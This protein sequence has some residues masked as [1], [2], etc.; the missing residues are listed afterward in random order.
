MNLLDQYIL[1]IFVFCPLIASIFIML[2]PAG[3]LGSKLVASKFFALLGFFAYARLMI[4]FLDQSVPTEVILSLGST[5]FRVNLTLFVSKYNMIMYGVASLVLLYNVFTYDIDNAKT[6]I[7]HVT[8]FLLSFVIYI[9]FSQND[10]RVALP[11]LSI[12]NFLV[13]FIIGSFDKVRRGF[14][15]FQMGI[16]IFSC[17][18]LALVLLQ[19]PQKNFPENTQPI[20]F[21]LILLPGLARLCMPMLAPFAKKLFLNADNIEGSFLIVFEQMAGFFVLNLVKTDLN[22]ISRSLFLFIVLATT[23]GIIY[24]GFSAI[25]DKNISIMPHYFLVFYSSIIVTT[26][27]ISNDDSMFNATMSL[28]ATNIL[29]FFCLPRFFEFYTNYPSQ[30]SNSLANKI[31][32]FI[33]ISMFIGIPGIG[34]GSSLWYLIYDFIQGSSSL[35]MPWAIV[36]V[37][38]VWLFVLVLLGIA[39]L[40]SLMNNQSIANPTTSPSSSYHIQPYILYSPVLMMITSWF[41]P[42]GI[43]FLAAQGL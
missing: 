28:Y 41:I 31:L 19:I 10:L 8:P 33:G 37:V 40:M 20:L 30:N 23:L 14:T 9:S 17:D 4:F 6:N 13:Y 21:S 24:L 2:I 25:I 5:Y 16:F 1:H 7:H 22:V 34:V 35:N 39:M 27:F 36:T 26:L 15:I 12:A 43:L 3:D 42:W 29:C 11:I 18:A 32:Y 38:F